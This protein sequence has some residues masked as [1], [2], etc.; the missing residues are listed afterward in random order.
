MPERGSSVGEPRRRGRKA[1]L[2]TIKAL[3]GVALVVWLVRSGRLDLHALF[4]VRVGW[5]FVGLC[6][7]QIVTFAMPLLR[8]YLLVRAL[9]LDVD[10]GLAT[11]VGLAGY[12]SA[13]VVPSSVGIDGTKIVMLARRVAGRMPDLLST[14]VLDRFLGL[15]AQILLA[16]VF[17]AMLLSGRAADLPWAMLGWAAL[18]VAIGLAAVVWVGTRSPGAGLARLPGGRAVLG[19]ASAVV[20]FRRRGKVL[21]QSFALS[22]LGHLG[23]LASAWLAFYCYGE[24]ASLI[25]VFAIAP[26]VNIAWALPV[27]P[28]GLG[29]SDSVAATLYPM[30]G[31]QAGAEVVM[32]LRGFMLFIFLLCGVVFLLPSSMSLRATIAAQRGRVASH[33]APIEPDEPASAPPC[34]GER[35]RDM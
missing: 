24:E 12:F 6:L 16:A 8:W 13:L 22:I 14:L 21:G 32:L 18:L 25:A 2:L 31:L 26:L 27:T 11:R 15:V 7:A 4:D 33:A 29:V 5:P 19:V 35:R 3:L 23:A 34:P 20:G 28:M 17:G 30:V 9:E 1:A 10:L